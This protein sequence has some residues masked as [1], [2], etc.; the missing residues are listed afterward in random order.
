MSP[1]S[2][3]NLFALGFGFALA[4]LLANGYQLITERP[5]SFRLLNSTE[6]SIRAVAA[7]PFL[8]FA[9]PF[10]ILRN[11]IRGRRIEN[12]RMEFVMMATVLAGVWSLMSGT[13]LINLF[14]IFG[15]A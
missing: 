1:E 4:A 12:R 13:V 11:T 14:R 10:I 5:A 2:I 6:A 3:Q 8:A 15:L 9:A 7:V